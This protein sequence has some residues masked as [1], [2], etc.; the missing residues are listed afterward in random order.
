VIQQ[1]KQR[2]MGRSRGVFG[3]EWGRKSHFCTTNLY[4]SNKITPKKKRK[5]ERKKKKWANLRIKNK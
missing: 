1:E 2:E 5:K 3:C 4:K